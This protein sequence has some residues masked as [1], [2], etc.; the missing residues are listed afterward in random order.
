MNSGQFA[1][2]FCACFF[3]GLFMFVTGIIVISNVMREEALKRGF[4]EYSQKTGEWKWREAKTDA[5]T[6]KV[7]N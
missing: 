5:E 1:T 6:E 2:G 7:R 3:A 4:A